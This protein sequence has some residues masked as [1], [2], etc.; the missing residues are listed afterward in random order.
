MLKD[1]R[2]RLLQI[3]AFQIPGASSVRVLLHRWR[4]VEI[5]KGTF[6]SQGVLIEPGFPEKVSIGNDVT[7]GAR[8]TIIAHFRD[9][10]APKRVTVRIGNH[11][12]IGP[13]AL[14]LAN[15]VIGEGAV[16]TAGSI[17]T[18][19]VAPY[20]VVRGNPA[21][22]IGRCP[23]PLGVRGKYYDFIRAFRPE[24]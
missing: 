22:V 14:I 20:T 23:V 8:V 10:T 2:N 12:F 4:G 7:L 17:V 15:V 21:K 13:H 3:I 6:I 24:G 11:A 9:Q 5:G 18:S 16:V 1:I 19:S